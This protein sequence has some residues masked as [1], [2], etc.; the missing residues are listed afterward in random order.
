MILTNRRI[1]E[2]YQA[3]SALSQRSLPSV[4]NDNRVAYW[5]SVFEPMVKARDAAITKANQRIEDAKG[6]DDEAVLAVVKAVHAEIDALESETFDVPTPTKKLT[7]A[8]MPKR[9]KGGESNA[10]G[11]ARI[12]VLL[13]PEFFDLTDPDASGVEPAE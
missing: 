11:V 8:D 2:L 1:V 3:F 6:D 4:A 10:A 12:K 13:A 9:W 7:D 5:L